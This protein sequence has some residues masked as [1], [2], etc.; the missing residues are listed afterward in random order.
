MNQKAA[1]TFD[2]PKSIYV[3]V[4][5]CEA[6]CPYCAFASAV[7]REGDEEL[8]L[9]SLAREMRRRAHGAWKIDTLYVGGGTPSVLS[10][11]SWERLISLIDENFSFSRRAEVTAEANPGSLSREHLV[12]WRSWRINRIS[13]GVQSFDDGRLAFLGR[14]H[15]SEQAKNA[16]RLCVDGG[17]SVSLD[18]MFGLPGETLRAWGTDLREAISAGPGH[19]SVYQLTAEPGTSFGKRNFSLPEGYAQYRYA[20]WRL[21]RAGYTQYEVASFSIPGR[22]SRHNLNYWNDGGYAGFGPS[23]WSHSGGERFKNTPSLDN[24]ALNAADSPVVFGERIEGERAARQ[25]AVLALRTSCG[26]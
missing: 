2:G 3:H 9:D 1:T 16:V 19:I 23:A 22:E 20:Q 24:Y 6:K 15:S 8:Y 26:I 17:F 5:F 7:K 12:L 25:A 10:P 4:P 18:M 21:P 13:L 14:A 11:R